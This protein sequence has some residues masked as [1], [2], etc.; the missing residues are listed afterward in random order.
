MGDFVGVAGALEPS[1]KSNHLQRSRHLGS[2]VS[3]VLPLSLWTLVLWKS[4]LSSVLLF[5]GVSKIFGQFRRFITVP[6]DHI[7]LQHLSSLAMSSSM[8]LDD[9]TDDVQRHRRPRSLTIVHQPD[10]AFNHSPFR[11]PGGNSDR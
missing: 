11:T 4:L 5:S 6:L 7:R 8:Q 2:Q 1:R 3:F 10:L 9:E